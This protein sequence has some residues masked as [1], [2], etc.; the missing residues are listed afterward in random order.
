MDN[1][2]KDSSSTR[3]QASPWMQVLNGNEWHSLPHRI[4][5]AFDEGVS[6]N[7]TRKCLCVESPL[8]NVNIELPTFKVAARALSRGNH[9]GDYSI[10][11]HDKM[12][13]ELGWFINITAAPRQRQGF[14]G[15][16]CRSVF[17][18]TCSHWLKEVWPYGGEHAHPKN[19]LPK[20]AI[21]DHLH[22]I[23]LTL[24]GWFYVYW[25]RWF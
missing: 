2:V 12:S 13:F 24:R 16:H 7:I 10:C 19:I 1:R 11:A 8:L 18:N 14:Q 15:F 6:I 3:N 9:S 5:C 25:G 21:V 17:L 20:T 22:G 4:S 23:L